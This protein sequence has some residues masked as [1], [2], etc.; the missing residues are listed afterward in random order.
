MATT[1]QNLIEQLQKNHNPDDSIIF[2]YMVSEYTS[3]TEE[4]FQPIA[5][6]IM[7]NESFGEESS[8]FFT[9]WITEANDVLLEEQECK[10]P[11]CV[12][13][14]DILDN[15]YCEECFDQACDQEENNNH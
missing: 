5:E 13:T 8:E 3:Y 1:V 7:D 4:K 11:S 15:G 10:C 2:Q 9:A 14:E 6:Y 12:E